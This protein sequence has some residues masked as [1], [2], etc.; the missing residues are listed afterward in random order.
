MVLLTRGKRGG[1]IQNKEQRMN[2]MLM[3]QFLAFSLFILTAAVLRAGNVEF[4]AAAQLDWASHDEGPVG[5]WLGVGYRPLAV[6][7]L[8]Y[9]LY[10]RV[11]PTDRDLPR[12]MS[13][14]YGLGIFGEWDV[15]C[16]CTVTPFARLS[17]GLLDT[18]GPEYPTAFE[19]G[20]SV[21]G[22]YALTKQVSLAVALSGMWT[23]EA[24][25]DYESKGGGKWDASHM[26]ATVD[27]GMRFAF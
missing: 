22:K 23:D 15:D 6:D 24:L 27:V 12:K 19:T 26:D 8:T 4:Q 11:Q 16:G 5:G 25:L 17:A 20:A 1:N 13:R 2:T 10:G 21:G 7:N 14:M 18:T 3:R 9:G